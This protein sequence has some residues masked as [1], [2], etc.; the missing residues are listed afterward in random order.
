MRTSLLRA[1]VRPQLPRWARERAG[2]S[3]AALAGRFPKLEAW[4]RG[5]G[6][7]TLEH[8]ESFALATY[9]PVGFLFL[10]ELPVETVPVPHFRAVENAHVG[11]PS[12]DLLGT[13]YLFQ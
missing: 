10:R 1:E 6:H 11:H 13:R 5:E 9:A 12:L 7:P 2:F 3:A 8:L 4:D